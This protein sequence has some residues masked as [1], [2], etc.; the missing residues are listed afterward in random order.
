MRLPRLIVMLVF[1]AVLAGCTKPKAEG[2]YEY[3]LHKAAGLGD[4]ERIKSLLAAGAD[5]NGLHCGMTPLHFACGGSAGH[6]AIEELIRAGADVNA[7][8]PDGRTPLH[9]VIACGPDRESVKM[10]TMLVAAGADVNAANDDGDTPL[11]LACDSGW[12]ETAALLIGAGAKLDVKNKEGRTPLH[13]ASSSGEVKIVEV[14]LGAKADV[15]ARDSNG[16]SALAMATWAGHPEVASLLEDAG[17]KESSW[18]PLHLAAIHGDADAAE[19]LIAAGGDVNKADRY[20]LTPLMWAAVTWSDEVAALLIEAKADVQTTDGDGM[21]ALLVAASARNNE[22]LKR[23]LKAGASVEDCDADGWRALHFAAYYGHDEVVT[24]LIGAGAEIDARTKAL[25]TPL[26]LAVQEQHTQAI[27]VLL[28]AGA[29][30]LAADEDGDTPDALAFG[31]SEET[32]K[33]IRPAAAEAIYA[34]LTRILARYDPADEDGIAAPS[35]IVADTPQKALLK[36]VRSIYLNDRQA[37]VSCFDD[38]AVNSSVIIAGFDNVQAL[39]S[40]RKSMIEAYGKDGWLEFQDYEHACLALPALDETELEAV[41][42][43]IAGNRA[44]VTG[45]KGLPGVGKV[46]LVRADGVWRISPDIV[47]AGTGDPA[48]FRS[49]A[50]R[51]TRI[52]HRV[53]ERIGEPGVTAE[54]IDRMMGK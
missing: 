22:T 51:M 46:E 28:D 20:G 18:S 29:D 5:V 44:E 6:S 19:E 8:M 7:R 31:G 9:L 15:E 49:L 48:A 32:K 45:L 2:E 35:S 1:V 41:A 11:H 4:V 17:A 42:V 52:I 16:W 38:T 12:R 34:R 37:Y 43:T 36:M 23:L 27:K 10:S 13:L 21:T 50:R 26:I 53:G 47:F 40:F 33:L 30:V 24:T 25:A 14:L 39:L 3:E 54:D